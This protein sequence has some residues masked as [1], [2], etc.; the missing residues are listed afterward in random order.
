MRV[1]I[2]EEMREALEQDP[3]M[4]RCIISNTECSGRIEWNHAF[5]YAGR[6][7]NEP[8]AL[9]PMCST[10]HGQE[11]AYR[12]QLRRA[13]QKRME[14]FELEDDA[15]GKYSKSDLFIHN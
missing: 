2:P 4:H 13:M 12:P 1:A 10:H 14:Y 8:W 15:R 11:A 6:R 7:R 9:Q 5:I 3:Y